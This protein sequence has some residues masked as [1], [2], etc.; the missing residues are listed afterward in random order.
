MSKLSSYGNLRCA[1]CLST[2][3]LKTTSPAARGRLR[4]AWRLA[5]PCLLSAQQLTLDPGMGLAGCSAIEPR[6]LGKEEKAHLLRPSICKRNR[7]MTGRVRHVILQD[8]PFVE[9][10]TFQDAALG[11]P[12]EWT[13]VSGILVGVHS[14]GSFGYDLL[15]RPREHVEVS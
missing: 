4:I 12:R 8:R 6:V 14:E 11:T 10:L 15:M 2:L 9:V 3:P 13:H 5:C 7:V 1:V